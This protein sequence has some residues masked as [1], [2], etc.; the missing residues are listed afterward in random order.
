[1]RRIL[2]CTSIVALSAAFILYEPA[3]SRDPGDEGLVASYRVNRTVSRLPGVSYSAFG[4]SITTGAKAVPVTSSYLHRIML[5]KRWVIANYAVASTE[6][7]DI[8]GS[9]I[10][11]KD[12]APEDEFVLLVGFNDMRRHGS[13]VDGL[14]SYESTLRAGLTW[15]AVPNTEKV[16]AQSPAV[17]YTGAWIDRTLYGLAAGRVSRDRGATASTTVHG[18]AV[19]IGYASRPSRPAGT[20]SVAIDGVHYGTIDGGQGIAPLSG[21]DYWPG[22]WRVGGLDEGPHDVVVTVTSPDGAAVHL[23]YI[24]G[25]GGLG[26]SVWPVV[27]VGNTLRMPAAGYGLADPW[28]QGS[29]AAVEQYNE[30]NRQVVEE[31]ASDGL[32]VVYVDANAHYDPDGGDVHTDNVHPNRSGHAKIAD[33][34]LAAINE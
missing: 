32:N 6:M 21:L 14:R 29:D 18:T 11:F 28:N 17:A 20:M 13:S 9:R 10:Y 8:S 19:Y 4:D 2:T 31:L 16:F 5:A 27:Y 24:A 34:F 25:N 26:Q 3:P 7:A 1:M 15:L 30:V 23:D 33:A 12:V 22:G